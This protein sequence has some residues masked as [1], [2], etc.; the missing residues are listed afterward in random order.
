MGGRRHRRILRRIILDSEDELLAR[1]DAS[2]LEGG[3]ASR[4][5]GLGGEY[6]PPRAVPA[7]LELVPH[8]R[9]RVRVHRFSQ[10]RDVRRSRQRDWDGLT[11][12][13]RGARGGRLLLQGGGRGA[14]FADAQGGSGLG[15]RDEELRARREGRAGRALRPQ[16]SQQPHL[17]PQLGAQIAAPSVLA[18][19]VSTFRLEPQRRGAQ[20]GLDR[21]LVGREHVRDASAPRIRRGFRGRG[22]G[23]NGERAPIR[24]ASATEA[25]DA[26]VSEAGGEHACD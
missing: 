21:Y 23:A 20:L 2:V 6:H 11:G 26:C 19:L 1:G 24:R 8:R 7:D 13:E 15:S 14:G 17:P 18:S 16:F 22:L 10:R 9:E 12:D 5:A 3:V 25:A 4:R